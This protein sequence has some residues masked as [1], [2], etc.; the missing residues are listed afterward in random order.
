MTPGSWITRPGSQVRHLYA[1]GLGLGG[2]QQRGSDVAWSGACS[3]SRM[4]LPDTRDDFPFVLDENMHLYRPCKR[5]VLILKNRV[6]WY[7]EILDAAWMDIRRS[8][9]EELVG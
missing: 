8:Q 1:I 5:C 7:R 2:W 4:T 9:P 3:M 6:D